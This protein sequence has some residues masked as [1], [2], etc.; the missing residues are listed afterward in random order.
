MA[1][2]SAT[3]FSLHDAY[4]RLLHLGIMAQRDG[5]EVAQARVK[6][7]IEGLEWAF[8]KLL[9]PPDHKKE[10]SDG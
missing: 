2:Y 7:T 6:K 9:P 8:P 10:P 5:D 1:S 3:N 4:V